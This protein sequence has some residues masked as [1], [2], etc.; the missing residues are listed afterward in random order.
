MRFQSIGNRFSSSFD[1]TVISEL[2]S[3]NLNAGISNSIQNNLLN[4]ETVLLNTPNNLGESYTPSNT[5]VSE[6]MFW[7]WL[8]DLGAIRFKDADSLETEQTNLFSEENPTLNG[9]N[10]VV[11]YL[12]DI[13]LINNVNNGGDSYS[14]IYLHIPTEH[15]STPDVLFKNLIDVNYGPNL[16]WETTPLIS[17]RTLNDIELGSPMTVTTYPHEVTVDNFIYRTLPDFSDT[18]TTDISISNST[19]G[20]NPYD[21]RISN[22][23]GLVIDWNEEDYKK[24]ANRQSVNSFADLN[25]EIEAQDFDFNAIL[26]YY[27]VFDTSNPSNTSRNLYGI[28]FLEDFTENIPGTGKLKTF[29]K[30]KPNTVNRVN[31]NSYSLKTNIK[32]LSN[33][34]KDEIINSYNEYSTFSMDLFSEAMTSLM[35]S[36]N[37]LKSNDFKILGLQEKVD[38]LEKYLYNQSSITDL[39]NIITDLQKS[40]NNALIGLE[41]PSTILE[42]IRKNSERINDLAKGNLGTLSYDLNPFRQGQG[43]KVDKGTPGRINI[44]NTVQEYNSINRCLNTSGNLSYLNGN[45]NPLDDDKNNIITF[46]NFTNYFKNNTDFT[47]L[48]TNNIIV[49]IQDTIFKFKKGQVYKIYFNNVLNLNDNV[50]IKIYTDAQNKFNVGSYKWLIGEVS[51]EDFISSKPILEIVCVD[52]ILYKFDLNIIR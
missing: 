6:R 13:S 8:T 4:W 14:E 26:I 42:L 10:K 51:S 18:T 41:S 34:G 49:N 21:L 32:F 47:G 45:G 50:K 39:K 30:I 2:I 20:S 12:G 44:E 23:D 37:L 48:V 11:K 22:T 5:T 35:S 46:G 19:D 31:G 9:Y 7:R 1:N 15:G 52:E 27:D 25:K 40:V 38:N 43:I 28:L 3:S 36:L 33:S 17:G 29:K 24:I 16:S